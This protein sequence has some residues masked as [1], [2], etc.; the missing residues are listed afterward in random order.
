[1]AEIVS[2][3][4][5]HDPCPTADVSWKTPVLKVALDA[6]RLSSE[7]VDF[8]VAHGLG[9][10]RVDEE[11]AGAWTDLGFGSR[12]WTALKG[13]TGYLGAATGA[14]ELAIG[15]ICSRRSFVP[16]AAGPIRNLAPSATNIVAG[17]PRTTDALHP[18][19]LFAARSWGGQVSLIA[20]RS[21]GGDAMA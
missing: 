7:D 3:G 5:T 2:A 16:P 12:P 6:A 1:M 9:L 8:V 11:E 4:L 20:V 10:P 13:Y 18:V 21:I 19:G 15:L 14:V 17:A